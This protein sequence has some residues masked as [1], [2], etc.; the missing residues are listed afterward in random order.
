MAARPSEFRPEIGDAICERL[1]DGES[2]RSICSD[3]D[4]PAKSTVMKWLASGEHQAFVDQYA[5]AR[6]LAGDAD[7][8][9]IGHIARQV[10]RGEIEPAAATAAINGLKWTA[11]KRQPKKYGDKVEVEH[12]GGMK[13]TRVELVGPSAAVELTAPE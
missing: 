3:D 8:D 12:S 4:M 11:A 9:D 6:E 1:I 2:L 5:R 7:F 10:A 13:I